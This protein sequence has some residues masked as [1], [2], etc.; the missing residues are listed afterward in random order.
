MFVLHVDLTIKPMSKEA[1]E[2]TYLEIFEPAISS[3]EGFTA[4]SLLRPLGDEEEYR[5]SI[6]FDRQASQ[7]KWVASDLH[8]QVWP[9]MESHCAGY[10]VKLYNTV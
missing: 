10:S 4:L 3:Q 5:L 1:L 6:A 8:R 9:Q 2:R 7:Q